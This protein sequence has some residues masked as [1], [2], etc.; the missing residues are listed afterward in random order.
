VINYLLTLAG[1]VVVVVLLIGAM[2]WIAPWLTARR[3]G[4]LAFFI[5]C[6]AVAHW[7]YSYIPAEAGDTWMQ[8]VWAGVAWIIVNGVIIGIRDFERLVGR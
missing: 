7:A 2:H 8:L 6:F 1:L 3:L 4:Q 5:G